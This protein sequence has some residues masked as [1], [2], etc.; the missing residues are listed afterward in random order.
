MTEEVTAT[1]EVD[2][3]A[4]AVWEVLTSPA[5]W[6]AWTDSVTEAELLDERFGLGA[7]VRV[8]QP[9]LRPAVW[10]V[11]DLEEG[12]AFTWT[13]RSPGVLTTASHVLLPAGPGRTELRLHLHHDG[14]LASLVHRLLGART[15]RYVEME[16]RGLK[17]AAEARTPTP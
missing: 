13:S 17:A 9:G 4:D 2:A 16:A 1:V 11:T 6:P 10:T 8:V 5:G 15:R 3:P 12:R 14:F 7:R